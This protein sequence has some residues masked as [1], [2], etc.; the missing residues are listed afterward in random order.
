MDR[1]MDR[2]SILIAGAPPATMLHPGILLQFEE[3]VTRFSRIDGI[4]MTRSQTVPDRTRT[5]AAPTVFTAEAPVFL[6]NNEVAEELFGPSTMIVRCKSR[7]EMMD[8]AR[9]LAGHLTATLQGTMEDLAEFAPLVRL[10]EN[11]VGRLIFNGF[12]TGVEVCPSIHHGGPYPATT[13]V[14]STSVGTAAIKRF[15]RP[16][17]YQNFP[18]RALPAE[19]R[20]QN[21]RNIWRLVD[22][23]WTKDGVANVL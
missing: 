15:A 11:R 18:D 5:E 16:I 21:Q 6:G 3:G 8:V 23:C 19:L 22:N 17:C 12:P 10:L 20:N 7:D 4:H 14:R 9:S 2:M 13:D 1:L